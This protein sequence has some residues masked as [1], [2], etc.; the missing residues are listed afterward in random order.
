MKRRYFVTLLASI[1]AVLA[2]LP[3]IAKDKSEIKQFVP[4]TDDEK[5]IM[6][7]VA[8]YNQNYEKPVLVSRI[9]TVESYAI[10]SW[11]LEESG[12]Q[13]LVRRNAE[14]QWK[15]VRGFGGQIDAA[16][17]K[18]FEVPDS[19]SKQLLKQIAEQIQADKPNPMEK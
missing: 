14:G 19:I 15:I 11:I 7:M 3:T 18:R 16:F 4:K 5:S 1:S 12:G 2:A 6:Q 10:Y 8:R 13:T 9:A 17:L